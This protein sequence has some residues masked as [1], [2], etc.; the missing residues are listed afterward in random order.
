M[1]IGRPEQGPE[2]GCRRLAVAVAGAIVAAVVVAVGVAVAVAGAIAVALAIA[3][4]AMDWCIPG[5]YVVAEEIDLSV[6][7][8]GPRRVE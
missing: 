6:G 5:R 8:M 4:A 1:L 2:L 3:A 7:L